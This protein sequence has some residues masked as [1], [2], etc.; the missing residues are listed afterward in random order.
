MLR[1][2]QV[3]LVAIT[4]VLGVL[5]SVKVILEWSR[6]PVGGKVIFFL[7]MPSSIMAVFHNLHRAI[8]EEISPLKAIVYSLSW[9]V[10]SAAVAYS[11]WFGQ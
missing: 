5:S 1:A 8:E 3:F 10:F 9:I 2:T 4:V 6:F 11:L 7:W